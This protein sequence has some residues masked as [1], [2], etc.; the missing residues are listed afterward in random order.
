MESVS[1][2]VQFDTAFI[3]TQ[4][5]FNSWN[6][7]KEVPGLAGLNMGSE[8]EIQSISCAESINLSICIA[9]GYTPTAPALPR[10]WS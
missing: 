2:R 1:G 4:Y 9:A 5:G 8:A 7:A 10:R 6:L 3:T